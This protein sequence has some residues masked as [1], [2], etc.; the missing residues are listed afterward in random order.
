MVE[1]RMQQ[2]VK[3]RVNK[4]IQNFPNYS[5]DEWIMDYPDQIV[6]TSLHLIITHEIYEMIRLLHKFKKKQRPPR[7]S[8]NMSQSV[9]AS[10]DTN[11]MLIRSQESEGR[12]KNSR[13]VDEND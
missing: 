11:T 5:L 1:M 6:I 13:D 8:N 9:S 4:A 3:S 10:F 2:T 12:F 7:V